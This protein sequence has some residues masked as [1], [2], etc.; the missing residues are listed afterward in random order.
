MVAVEADGSG[1]SKRWR[2]A[3]WTVESNT[4]N[5]HGCGTGLNE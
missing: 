3:N 1:R 2:D 5:K 4:A